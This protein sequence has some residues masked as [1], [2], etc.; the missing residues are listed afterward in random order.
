MIVVAIFSDIEIA[1]AQTPKPV[2]RIA[3]EIGLLEDE[4]ESY[5]KYKAK[6]ELSVIDRLSHRKDGKY[7]V[8]AG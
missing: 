7:I 3:Q 1:V 6:I 2:V 5:G 8:V 4:V